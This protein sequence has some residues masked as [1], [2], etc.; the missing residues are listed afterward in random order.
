MRR[1]SLS[2]LQLATASVAGQLIGFAALA[3]VARRIGPANLGAYGFAISFVGYVTLPLAGLGMRGIRDVA[4]DRA[5]APAIVGRLFPI[6]ATYAVAAGGAVYVLAPYLAPTAIEASLMRI[7][8]AWLVVTLMSLDWLLQG[9]QEF[10]A[11]AVA[12]VLGQL[13]YGTGV[14]LFIQGGAAGTYRYAWLNTFG[15][16]VTLVGTWAWT[17]R[18]VGLPTVHADVRA[19]WAT[20]RGSTAF[21]ASF[22][23]IQVY[24]SADVVL[25]GFLST[26]TAVGHYVV[27]YKV[28]LFFLSMASLWIQVFYP[29][30]ATQP[31]EELRRHIGRLTTLT[32]VF[33]IPLCAGCFM[34]GR[35][36]ISTLFGAQFV[37]AGLSF[38]LLMISVAFAAIDA[39]VGQ[40]LLA[41]GEQRAFAVGV[42]AGA[43]ANLAL[44]IILIPSSG[45]VGAAIST[46]VA[47]AVVLV[48]MASRIATALGRPHILW[49]R[50]V[51]AGV[52]AACMVAMLA[53]PFRHLPLPVRILAGAGVYVMCGIVTGAAPLR[54]YAMALRAISLSKD[55]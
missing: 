46:I 23:M 10:R 44:N 51:W 15:L 25:L 48:L 8:I 36:L 21:I 7:L 41:I 19:A 33:V 5:A 54:E 34:V 27:A 14:F 4:Q 18:R 16:F 40:V 12:R 53:V 13:A 17:F 47:E 39:N 6:Y 2:F 45:A 28:P 26:P 3:V 22:V 31:R 32:F 30:A 29:H 38:K 11:V 37:A 55:G 1:L 20:L 9:L 42:T 35:S 49:T 50:V 43:I 24:Y 52:S